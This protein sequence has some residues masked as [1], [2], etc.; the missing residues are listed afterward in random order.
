MVN[1][2]RVSADQPLNNLMTKGKIREFSAIP[3]SLQLMFDQTLRNL[4]VCLTISQNNYTQELHK[5]A[6]MLQWMLG[7][8]GYS[9]NDFE[10]R[11]AKSNRGGTFND[12]HA[13][14]VSLCS[15]SRRT[16]Y[17]TLY[18]AL[19]RCSLPGR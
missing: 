10:M 2:V 17:R 11:L 5:R 6:C 13:L 3:F 12:R 15:A 16:I 7:K 19:S 9:Q 18:Q 1:T 14:E 8:F 4:V